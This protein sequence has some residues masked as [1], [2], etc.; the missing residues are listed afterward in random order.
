MPLGPESWTEVL[1]DNEYQHHG[2]NQPRRLPRPEREITR[3]SRKY[4]LGV[5]SALGQVKAAPGD[6]LDDEKRQKD[7]QIID[8]HKALKAP[9]RQDQPGP[10]NPV[11]NPGV[12]RQPRNGEDA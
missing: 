10:A 3:Q 4:A 1:P 5:E 9:I 12:D 7:R 11:D 2:H 8:Q 6:E